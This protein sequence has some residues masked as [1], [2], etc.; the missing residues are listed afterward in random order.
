L[1]ELATDILPPAQGEFELEAEPGKYPDYERKLRSVMEVY[2]EITEAFIVTLTNLDANSTSVMVG[3]TQQGLEGERLEAV[4]AEIVEM[5]QAIIPKDREI[6]VVPDVNNPT[7]PYSA[8][9]RDAVPF[10]MRPDVD[11]SEPSIFNKVLDRY[12]PNLGEEKD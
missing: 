9:F 10:Y 7:Y 6:A 1:E 5:A 12:R 8:L 3:L 11:S 2:E 4:S